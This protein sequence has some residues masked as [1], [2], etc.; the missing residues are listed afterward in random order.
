M[1][2]KVNLSKIDKKRNKLLKVNKNIANVSYRLDKC[3]QLKVQKMHK[4]RH[5]K[6][7]YVPTLRRFY[8]FKYKAEIRKTISILRHRHYAYR[9]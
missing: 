9:K 8:Y 6:N 5:Q 7:G 4:K 1:R 3:L 2:K